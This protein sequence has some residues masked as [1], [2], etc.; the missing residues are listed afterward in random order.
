M[1]WDMRV[2]LVLEISTYKW[3]YAGVCNV[4]YAYERRLIVC[5]KDKKREKTI[6]PDK[7][8]LNYPPSRNQP[9]HTLVIDAQHEHFMMDFCTTVA[10]DSHC[11]TVPDNVPGDCNW[12]V[13][14][15]RFGN[16]KYT[17]NT[18]KLHTDSFTWFFI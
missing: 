12:L 16:I 3:N 1:T 18:Q 17:W 7:P 14:L 6:F 8:I 13:F 2:H 4:F 15:F 5:R 11:M 9:R 10:L